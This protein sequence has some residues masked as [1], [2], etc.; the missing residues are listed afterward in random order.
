M[1]KPIE[2]IHRDGSGRIIIDATKDIVISLREQDA[3]TAVKCNQGHCAFAEAAK[4]EMPGL[5]EVKFGKLFTRL[6]FPEHVVRYSNS[7]AV[8]RQIN[9]FDKTGHFDP[10]EYRLN[11]I[12]PHD[13]IGARTSRGL[14]PKREHK[15]K[16]VTAPRKTRTVDARP[17][18]WSFKPKTK[19]AK[20]QV[21]K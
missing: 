4:R 6:C 2:Q 3:S 17:T 7:R 1:P 12:A 10:D 14:D 21:A 15:S 11:A 18:S 5:V 8:T 16:N 19:R 13:L 9:A 20:A